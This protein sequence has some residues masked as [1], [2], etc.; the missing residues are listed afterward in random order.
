[1]VLFN[2]DAS[3]FYQGSLPIGINKEQLLF[4]PLGILSGIMGTMYI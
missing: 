2:A 3:Y 1:V 4:I